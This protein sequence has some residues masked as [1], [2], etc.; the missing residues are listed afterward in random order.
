LGVLLSRS[1]ISVHLLDM[2]PQASLSRAFGQADPAD[3]L[4][5][6]FASRAS[7]PVDT[8]APKSHVKPKQH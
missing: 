5:H 4:Y 2:D 1:G 3:R 6:S 7:L 8:L